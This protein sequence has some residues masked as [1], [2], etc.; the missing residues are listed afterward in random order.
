MNQ[1]R[2]KATATG[3]DG[4]SPLAAWA[5]AVA[6]VR[7]WAAG[8]AAGGDSF[9]SGQFPFV[10]GGGERHDD[11]VSGEGRVR[12]PSCV[13]QFIK[14]PYGQ[15]IVIEFQGLGALGWGEVDGV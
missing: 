6:T 2:L 11:D 4:F 9:G 1:V 12:G 7:D 5:L 14:N 15:I 10:R 3:L 8:S 13:G